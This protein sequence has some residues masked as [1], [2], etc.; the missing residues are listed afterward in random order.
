MPGSVGAVN[1][2]E[3]SIFTNDDNDMLDWGSGRAV[4]LKLFGVSWHPADAGNHAQHDSGQSDAGS[5]SSRQRF[6]LFHSRT[7]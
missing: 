2:V 3:G 6:A 7:P 1:I 4:A 5:T